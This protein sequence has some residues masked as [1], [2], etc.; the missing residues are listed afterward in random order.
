MQEEE[1]KNSLDSKKALLNNYAKYSAVGFQMFAIIGAFAYAGYKID[2][3]RQAETPLATAF[4]SLAGVLIA[5]Y[6]VIR[7]LRKIKP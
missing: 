3:N 2:K 1:S 5:L 7:T 4:L 6:I